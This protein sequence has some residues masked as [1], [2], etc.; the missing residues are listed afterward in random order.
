MK[1]YNI[2]VTEDEMLII[3][4]ALNQYYMVGVGH[5]KAMLSTYKWTTVPQIVYD[6][7]ELA[8]NQLTGL[9]KCVL[10]GINDPKVDPD[11]SAAELLYDKLKKIH[12]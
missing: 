11:C 8:T 1:K 4:K 12:E 3:E 5:F 6:L 9:P 7:L 2:E 10:W